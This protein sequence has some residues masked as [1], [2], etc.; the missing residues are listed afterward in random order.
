MSSDIPP[1]EDEDLT[2]ALDRSLHAVAARMTGGLS[3]EAMLGAW[4]D[5]SVHLAGSPGRRA[6]LLC[7]AVDK[8]RRLETWTLE[9]LG[10]GQAAAPVIAA[11]SGDRRFDG[12]GWNG[13]PF[14]LMQQQ[15]LLAQEWW[16]EATTGLGGVTPQHEKAVAFAARQLLDAASPSNFPWTNPEVIERTLETSGIN[17]IAGYQKWLKDVSEL[18]PADDEDRAPAFRPGRDVATTPGKVIYRNL[19]IELIQYEP[20]TE[21]VRPEPVLIAPAWIMKYYILDLSPQNS[22]VRYLV[23][24]GYTV[25]M[26]SWRNP[27]AA[28]RDLTLDDYRMFGVMEALDAIG[29]IVPD[30]KVH[31]VGYCLG[32][33]LLSIAAATMARDK[34]E[35][36]ATV[37]L[38]AAQTDFTEAGELTLFINPAQLQFL[39]DMMWEQGY[40]D[41][42]Q[43]GGSFEI[44]RSKDL[45]WS[46]MVR[47][48]MMGEHQAPNDLMSW[49]ADQ[50][51]MPYRMHSEYLHRLFM[52]NALASGRY[53][54]E[55]DPIALVDIRAPIF[56]VGTERDHVAPW[57]SVFKIHL[58]ARAEVTFALTSG[59][60]N[61]GIVSEPGHAGRR[62]RLH[63]Q[64]PIDHYIDP[65]RWV[66][67]ATMIEGS[68]WTAW[69][70]WLDDRSGPPVA[71]PVMGDPVADAPGDYVFQY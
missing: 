20:T 17:F 31:A 2:D 39:E 66:E 27:D 30:R 58:L 16:S 8:A 69:A 45:I 54:V 44:L 49:N 25:F 7:S 63:T 19:L 21:T 12:A 38:L 36:L 46:R 52:D 64:N 4:L 32:G 10:A 29:G 71:P 11:G 13:W 22:L 42:S 51:R 24:Q 23:E 5:W 70:S 48:Y 60:H 18:A 47:E 14:N 62:Y 6:E 35:R 28:D 34:D 37:S 1:R 41:G 26:I 68:W 57:K 50:T 67:Q 65:D 55:G 59:G 9:S 40:L 15:F 61:A 56:A 43:M 33:T 53:L 3:P